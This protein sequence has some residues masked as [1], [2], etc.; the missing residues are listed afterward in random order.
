[1][2]VKILDV[3]EKNNV[4]RIEVETIYGKDNIGLNIEK[5][6]IDPETGKP[7]FL[8]EIQEILERK[9][10]TNT[11]KK[12]VTEANQFKGKVFTIDKLHKGENGKNKDI[13]LV[14]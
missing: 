1:M 7:R 11:E 10:V 9:Y 12:E 14:Y 4:L 13:D 3:Y 8:K 6:Y 5:K 2:E